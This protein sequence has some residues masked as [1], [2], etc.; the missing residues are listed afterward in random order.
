V[1]PF[2]LAAFLINSF[3]LDTQLN[4][5][6]RG[7]QHAQLCHPGHPLTGHFGRKYSWYAFTAP[8][9]DNDFVHDKR[10]D[11]WSL[12]A[13][14]YTMLCG[15]FPFQGDGGDLICSKH[16]GEVAFDA[17]IVSEEAQDL[18]RGLLQASPENRFTINDVLEHKW[19]CEDDVVLYRHDITLAA[20]ILEDWK[21]LER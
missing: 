15:I 18:V 5:S 7:I 19:M 12:G 10:V 9:M 6:I 11:L 16:T 3:H 13:I 17:V 8:E 2:C 4:L 14:L 20:E 21:N 1:L